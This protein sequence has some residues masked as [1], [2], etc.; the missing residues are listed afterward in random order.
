MTG[1]TRIWSC[2]GCLA[3][4]HIFFP[5]RRSQF[6]PSS[7]RKGR[8][9][10][11]V[12]TC[13][14]VYSTSGRSISIFTLSFM[15]E[16]HNLKLHRIERFP[17]TTIS[18]T[19]STTVFNL[20]S[21]EVRNDAYTIFRTYENRPERLLKLIDV[22]LLQTDISTRAGRSIQDACRLYQTRWGS[23]GI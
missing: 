13:L 23:G 15:P 5:K 6:E 19:L 22:F 2:S 4:I 3:M 12:V 17:S 1:M 8:K 20:A 10:K 9:I 7:K 11:Y 21:H 18:T 16:Y 14:N